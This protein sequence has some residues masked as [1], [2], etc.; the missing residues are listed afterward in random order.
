MNL[1]CKIFERNKMKGIAVIL[2]FV[3]FSAQPV[4]AQT[5]PADPVAAANIQNKISLEMKGMEVV[6]ALKILTDTPKMNIVIGKNVSGR[7]TLFLKEVDAV[8]AFEMIIS[9]A[10][11]AYEK[12]GGIINVMTQRDFELIYGYRFGNSK[13]TE[14]I[15]LKYIKVTEL[16]KSLNQLKTGIGK[17]VADEGTNTV[18]LI[19]AP[20][21]VK[22]MVE[23]IAK[24]D[25]PVE[26]KI[27][28]LN[29]A[30]ADKLSAKLQETV[31]KGVGLI[32]ADERTNKIA[33]TDYPQKIDEIAR[34]ISS[35]DEKTPQV[36]IDAQ[37]IEVKPSDRFQ[38]GFDWD[39]WIKK[40][41]D[42]KASLPINTAGALLV[43]T[44]ASTSANAPGKFKA[45]V[46]ILRTIGDTKILSSPRI[47][48]L[49]NQEAKIHIGTKDAYITS[50]T[51]QSSTGPNVTSQS[52]NFVDT[53]IQ[54]RVT[55]SINR[56]GF[57]TMKIK[58]EVSDAVLTN[59]I[60]Q[61]LTT[62]VPIVTI[63][64][65]ETTVMV[66]DGLT[67][68]IGGLRKDTHVKTV[69]KI[70]LLG[71][72][73]GLGHLFRTID[74]KVETDDLVILITPHIISG[75]KPYSG[76]AELPPKD[77]AV[78]KMS[79]GEIVI[80]KVNANNKTAESDYYELITAKVKGLAATGR[81]FGKKGQVRFSFALNSEGKLVAGPYI[82]ET[83]N[84]SLNRHVMTAIRA[85]EP[86]PPFPPELNKGKE[87]FKICL[88]YE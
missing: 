6:D 86:F 84:A 34:I 15:H 1:I 74:D 19:D 11:L 61:D 29:Y 27:F 75:E 42:L 40:Y 64:E 76:F 72:I 22:N 13:K 9:A 71:D 55:P 67:I 59:L 62:Q 28:D 37:L 25:I 87:I 73:P 39:F 35:F 17:V 33:V 26:T 8:D 41:F 45:V 66:K 36:L 7:I 10:D 48:A 78:A 52:V 51:S 47:M 18:A 46:D 82:L 54:L 31:T 81:I 57:V 12:S 56:D 83:T 70:P 63:S 23:F 21:A 65:S 43:G 14:I 85:A 5:Q 50:S 79:D 77:G 44:A 68:I 32:R 2:I 30:Q 88:E 80:N 16:L 3:I 69:K 24:T 4:F 49:N 60:S 58:P 53:G 20:L 38:M